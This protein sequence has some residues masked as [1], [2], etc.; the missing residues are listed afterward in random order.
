MKR[1][2]YPLSI[3]MILILT[4]S[5]SYWL[6]R[7]HPSEPSASASSS[8]ATSR[9]TLYWYD[10]MLPQQHFAKPGLSPMGM[11]LVPKY[12]GDEQAAGTVH[13][14]ASTVQNLGVRVVP[15]QHRVLDDAFQSPGTVTWD[16]REAMTVSARVDAIITHLYVR[17]PYTSV[18][19]GEPLADVLAPQWRSALAEADALEHVQSADAQALREAA[20]QRLQVLGLTPAD[21]RGAHA[22]DGSITLH[23]PQDG[24]VTSLDVQEGQRVAAGQTLMTLNSANSVWVDAAVPQAMVGQ[25]HA[26]TPVTVR[27][28]AW[29][30]QPLNA[31]VESVLPDVDPVTRAQRVRIALR[32]LQERLSPGQFVQVAF[33]PAPSQPVM[34][35]P[36]EAL[37]STGAHPR[38]IVALSKGQFRPVAVQTGRSANGYTEISAGLH[39]DE[40]VVVSGQ[41]LIDSEASLSGALERLSGDEGGAP[42]PAKALSASMP[43]GSEP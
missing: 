12:A 37:I 29:P 17:A 27:S 13:V 21:M 8:T 32:N 20:R 7:R 26:G 3:V 15:V 22:R 10:P 41:F 36:D 5:A 38:V 16:L 19:A 31:K 2:I 30:D 1:A 33:T 43:M 9:T 40:K 18:T 24:V 6:G 42:S 4:A 35:V 11:Q 39:G 25:V 34:V 23:A 14:D 28:D